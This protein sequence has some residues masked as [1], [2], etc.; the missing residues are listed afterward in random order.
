MRSCRDEA[1]RG[2]NHTDLA[3]QQR[4]ARQTMNPEASDPLLTNGTQP[5]RSVRLAV[6]NQIDHKTTF[7]K[8]QHYTNDGIQQH[9]LSG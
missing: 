5:S 8:M 9:P 6:S 1:D 4:A 3:N 7:A 2:G